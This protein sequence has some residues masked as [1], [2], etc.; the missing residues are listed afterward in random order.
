MDEIQINLCDELVKEMRKLQFNEASIEVIKSDGKFIE[1]YDK[2]P[3]IQK[4]ILTMLLYNVLMNSNTIVPS[5]IRIA[6]N[7]SND[8]IGWLDDIK[9][10]I[11]GFLKV[12]EET[13]FSK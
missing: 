3:I 2:Q 8:V 10:V 6:L 13:F 1:A 4:T 7:A 12:N 11:L 5:Q 9:L